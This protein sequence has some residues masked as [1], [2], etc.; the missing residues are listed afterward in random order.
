MRLHIRRA[1]VI[2]GVVVSLVVG[3]ASIQVAAALTAAAAPPPPPP[4]SLDSLQAA[5]AQEQARGAELQAQLG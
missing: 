5:L 4:V 3:L 1:F 2:A